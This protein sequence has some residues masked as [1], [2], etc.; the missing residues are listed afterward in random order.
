MLLL[1]HRA[2]QARVQR[3]AQKLLRM[4]VWL[5]CRAVEQVPQVALCRRQSKR[6]R[7]VRLA[8]QGLAWVL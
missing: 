8:Q 3:A 7:G 4:A 6:V 2:E 1:L 5:M